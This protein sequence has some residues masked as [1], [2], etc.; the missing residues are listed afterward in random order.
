V[1]GPNWDPAP[2]KAL[3]PDTIADAVVC[4]QAGA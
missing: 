2:G 4:L 3:R 1:I